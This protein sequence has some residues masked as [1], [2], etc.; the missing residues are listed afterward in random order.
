MFT[1]LTS[2]Q[3][4]AF[5][6][7]RAGGSINIMKLVKLMYLADR[8]SMSRYGA[9]I[10][11]DRM[12]S[13]DEGPVLSRTL[14][15]INGDV[16]KKAAA[17]WDS[18]ITAREGHQVSA[19]KEVTPDALDRLSDADLEVMEDTWKRFGHMDQ[20]DLSKYTHKNCAEWRDPDG[21]ALPIA[22]TDVLMALGRTQERAVAEAER[23]RRERELDTILEQL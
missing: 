4:A 16:S 22:E 9:P 7:T 20:W 10:S 2:A 18:W 21:S 8:E 19:R 1:P 5:F 6:A 17:I 13:M 12:V 11:F 23:L 3:I 15:L 14:N